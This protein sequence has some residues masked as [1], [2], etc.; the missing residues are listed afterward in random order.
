MKLCCQLTGRSS[1]TAKHLN[2]DDDNDDDDDGSRQERIDPTEPSVGRIAGAVVAILLMIAIVLV[3]VSPP[4][5]H[6]PSVPS[7]TWHPAPHCHY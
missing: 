4:P 1:L 7:M 2:S 5:Y 3:I 6:C